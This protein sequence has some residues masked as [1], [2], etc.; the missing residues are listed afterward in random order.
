MPRYVAV[1]LMCVSIAVILIPASAYVFMVHYRRYLHSGTK[2]R[3]ITVASDLFDRK[4]AA[5]TL[6]N[7][8]IQRVTVHLQTSMR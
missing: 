1:N 5:N 4:S 8:D 6:Y 3:R 2:A 7:S